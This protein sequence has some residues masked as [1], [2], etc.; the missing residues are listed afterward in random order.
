[1]TEPL[2]LSLLF[3]KS[4]TLS[5]FPGDSVVKNPLASAGYI[6]SMPACPTCRGA[7]KRMRHSCRAQPL[8]FPSASAEARVLKEGIKGAI[9]RRIPGTGEPGGLPSMGPHRLGHD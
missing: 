6:D 9:Q 4:R 2:T 8:E 5:S 7:A 3:F 1:M